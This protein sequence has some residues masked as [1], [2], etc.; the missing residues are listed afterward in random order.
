MG[1]IRF[2]LSLPMRSRLLCLRIFLLSGVYRWRILHRPFS[3]LSP[4]IGR[5]NQE[6]PVE[7]IRDPYLGAAAFF[8]ERVCR[9]TPWESKCLVQ[10]LTARQL[11]VKKGFPCTLYMG[12]RRDETGAMIAHA[13]LRCGDQYITGGSG[14]GYTV[15]NRYAADHQ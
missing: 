9:Y 6:T 14:A 4:K 13:W 15:T 5:L 2:L 10:A 8:V 12:V 11:L 1:K 3:E 7:P